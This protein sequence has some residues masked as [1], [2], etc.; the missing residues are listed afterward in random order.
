VSIAKAV[1]DPPDKPQELY[2]ALV[3]PNVLFRAIKSDELN[4]LISVVLK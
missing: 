2:S 1:Y 3:L 4:S